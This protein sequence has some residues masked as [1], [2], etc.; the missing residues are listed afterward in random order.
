VTGRLGLT[1]D[2]LWGFATLVWP[3]S[4]IML[5]ALILL[6]RRVWPAIAAGALLVN[7]W[8]GASLPE[9]MGIALGSTLGPIVGVALLSR[10]RDFRPEFDRPVDVVAFVIFAACIGPALSAPI[11]VL[12]LVAGQRVPV[13]GF[14]PTVL[15][16]WWGDA[17]SNLVIAPLILT[18]WRR[19]RLPIS[20]RYETAA[21]AGAVLLVSA[22][23]FLRP[24][25]TVKVYVILP[26]LMWCTARLGVRG[27]TAATLLVSAIAIAG[28][29]LG[30]GPFADLGLSSGLQALHLFIAIAAV[31]GLVLGAAIAAR[32][33]THALLEQASDPL[34]IAD[35]NG[36]ITLVNAAA[37]RILGYEPAELEGKAF[38]ALAD[39]SP[40]GALL[41]AELGA[42]DPLVAECSLKRKDGSQ[43]ETE[44][45]AK[46]LSTGQQQFLV[47]DITERRRHEE[48]VAL[49]RARL[50]GI[51]SLAVD[52]II[53]VDEGGKILIYNAGAEQIFASEA[54]VARRTAD[55]RPVFGLRKNGEEF[56][57]EAAISKLSLPGGPLFTVILR[58]ISEQRRALYEKELLLREIHHRVKN[59]LQVLSSL[60]YL[61]SRQTKDDEVSRLLEES[62][63][64]VQAIA[65]VHEQL[66][67]SRGVSKVDFG[68]Y[69]SA[70]VAALERTYAGDGAA[71]TQVAVHVDAEPVLLDVE[72]AVPCGLFVSELVSNAY[73][74]AFPSD[75]NGGIAVI[76]RQDGP[77]GML[78]EVADDG[79]G[80]EPGFDWRHP[81]SLG[82]QLVQTLAIQL[83]GALELDRSHGT[84]WVLR[85]AKT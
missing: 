59:S 8:A 45:S 82:L 76:A 3:P 53:S 39:E 42:Q 36:R 83:R 14:A 20:H 85:F 35:A 25:E 80:L 62:R 40:G 70:L 55:R 24:G 9:A 49:W 4:G 78:V 69:L 22:V 72:H 84:R 11:G 5:A 48:A 13:D 73:R 74:H 2:A 50:D 29:A 30:R 27:T 77:S 19:P 16:W 15:A 23:E 10:A 65:L 18:W 1:L 51:V 17:T 79:V 47:R 54:Q 63:S 38:V 66:Y 56:P 61:Q 43:V 60:F 32:D 31:Q 21:I 64:R 81:A 41:R 75:R 44:V 58:D 57:V 46:I 67:R 12:A 37:C 26:V 52:A 7:L 28:T 34:F 6:G 68:D 33:N 71:S